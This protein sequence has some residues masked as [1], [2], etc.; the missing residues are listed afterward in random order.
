MSTV[1][2]HVG[3]C[4]VC[5][6]TFKVRSQLLVHHGYERPGYG[7]IVGDCFGVNRPPHELSPRTAE[8][9]LSEAVVPRIREVEKWIQRLGPPG[10][11][12]Q[13]SFDEYD[14]RSRQYVPGMKRRSE[15]KDYDWTNRLR[16]TREQAADELASLQK[17]AGRLETLIAEWRP[18]PLR[19][20]EEE[21]EAHREVKAV[22]H[23]RVSADR[24]QRSAHALVNLQQQIDRAVKK[25][26]SYDLIDL[27]CGA[28]Q[29]VSGPL[30]RM[31]ALTHEQVLKLVD[32]DEVWAALGFMRGREYLSR[33]DARQVEDQR[34]SGV[35]WPK[36][37]AVSRET[38]AQVKTERA[39]K[40]QAKERAEID[41]RH[42]QHVGWVEKAL[43]AHNMKAL[44]QAFL[45]AELPY[46]IGKKLPDKGRSQ[47]IPLLGMDDLWVALGW[48]HRDGIYF[49]QGDFE[50]AIGAPYWD[51]DR[52]DPSGL[53]QWPPGF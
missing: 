32:R 37:R 17:E 53:F 12:E 20:V 40:K 19:T 16:R 18:Q 50:K 10:E 38:L 8:E 42:A 9:Y 6:G 33:R 23:A 36:P 35:A 44:M 11:P 7:Y 2:R 13:L 4:P 45:S 15:V 26:D 47:M 22:Q 24:E 1:L 52:F 34:G 43:R 41:S 46:D 51:S 27:F 21:E 30:G 5:E 39:A 29:K 14:P 48:V 31:A 25:Q 3:W 49:D 28:E